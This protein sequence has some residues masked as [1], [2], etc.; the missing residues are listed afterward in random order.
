MFAIAHITANVD[1]RTSDVIGMS[2]V[3][4]VTVTVRPRQTRL[5]YSA[6]SWAATPLQS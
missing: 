1:Q 2:R 4:T 6:S 5:A 3:R